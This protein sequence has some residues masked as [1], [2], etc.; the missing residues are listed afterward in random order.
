MEQKVEFINWLIKNNDILETNNFLDIETDIEEFINNLNSLNFNE[1][2]FFVKDINSFEEFIDKLHSNEYFNDLIDQFPVTLEMIKLYKYFIAPNDNQN[3][4]I[5]DKTFINPISKSET[6]YIIDENGMIDYKKTSTQGSY[7]ISNF[8]FK[9]GKDNG[10]FIPTTIDDYNRPS[11]EIPFT[12]APK[13][14]LELGN[15]IKWL[16]NIDEEITNHKLIIS[17]NITNNKPQIYRAAYKKLYSVTKS[18][19]YLW[20]IN[21]YN[22]NLTCFDLMFIFS[23]TQNKVIIDLKLSNQIC[24]NQTD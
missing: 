5:E 16:L 7:N 22:R 8:I 24:S 9:Y 1:N 21:L 20:F 10:F 3:I 12:L 13:Y 4:F 14:T 19:E 11:T 6:I 18:D 23:A 17:K 2:D 15:G